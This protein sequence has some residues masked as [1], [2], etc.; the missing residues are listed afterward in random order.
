MAK[1]PTTKDK[2]DV[3]PTSKTRCPKCASTDRVAYFGVVTREIHGVDETGQPYTH[4][5][6]RRTRCKAC[7]QTRIDRHRENRS[8][9]SEQPS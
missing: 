9:Q 8:S 2:P 3:V 7:D 4:V 6:W 1:K 5:V